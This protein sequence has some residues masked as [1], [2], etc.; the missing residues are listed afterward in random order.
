MNTFW[1][2]DKL[3]FGVR[4]TGETNSYIVTISFDHILDKIQRKI[5]DNKNLLEFKCIYD[6]LI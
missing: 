2:N 3:M 1:K 4:V 5:H 6:A